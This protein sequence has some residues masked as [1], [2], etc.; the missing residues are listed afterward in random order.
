MT[1]LLEE[2]LSTPKRA[3]LVRSFPVPTGGFGDA[4][5]L[6]DWVLFMLSDAADFLCGSVVFVDGGT[7]AY[8]R[9]NDSPR[10]VL[11]MVC[12]PTSNDSEPGFAGSRGKTRLG[13]SI[14]VRQGC[15]ARIPSQLTRCD[16][17]G[18][19]AVSVGSPMVSNGRAP[20]G[21]GLAPNLTQTEDPG[22]SPVGLCR[23]APESLP[24]RLR[25][26]HHPGYFRRSSAASTLPSTFADSSASAV[27]GSLSQLTISGWRLAG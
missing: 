23:L 9:A 26:E 1:P 25:P 16:T 19:N 27:T 5:Q 8:F 12:C 13:C 7:D 20:G 24:P 6:A 10:P 18:L 15:G 21:S 3:K 11:S 2:Q 14:A 17:A 4:G 22:A